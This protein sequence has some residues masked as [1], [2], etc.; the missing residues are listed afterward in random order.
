MLVSVLG[1][2]M[3]FDR[4]KSGGDELIRLCFEVVAWALDGWRLLRGVS[5]LIDIVDVSGTNWMSWVLQSQFVPCCLQAHF[6][7]R[8]EHIFT[9]VSW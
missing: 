7:W 2:V 5:G 1:A 9:G 6:H 4:A 3:L 8:D